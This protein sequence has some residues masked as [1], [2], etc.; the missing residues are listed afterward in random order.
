MNKKILGISIDGIIRDFIGQLTKIYED[1]IGNP[2]LPINSYNLEEHFPFQGGLEEFNHFLY[3]EFVLEIFGHAKETSLNAMMYVNQLSEK[4]KCFNCKIKL[5]S[6]ELGKSKSAT[7]FFLSKVGCQIDEIIFVK[8]EEDKWLH[9]DILLDINPFALENK[10]E[11]KISIKLVTEYN[12]EIIS[13]YTIDNI[14][15]LLEDDK[16]LEEI[17]NY[18]FIDYEEVK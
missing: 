13:N 5:I 16:F 7:L 11:D 18:D 1:Q 17:I 6:K 8:K 15:I 9:C 14:K 10:P 12:K 4:V 3:D 2:N